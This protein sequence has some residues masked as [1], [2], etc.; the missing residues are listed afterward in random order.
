M[1]DLANSLSKAWG[2]GSANSQRPNDV[3]QQWLTSVDEETVDSIR[4]TANEQF[5]VLHSLFMS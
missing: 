5:Q 4:E 1:T 2:M 3:A